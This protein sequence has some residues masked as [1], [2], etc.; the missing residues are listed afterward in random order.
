V[1]REGDAVVTLG[2]GNV[3][4]AGDRLLARLKT[5]AAEGAED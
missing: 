5:A 4:Q 2:A 3:G 1:A